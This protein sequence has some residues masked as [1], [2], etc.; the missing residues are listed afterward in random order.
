MN[1]FA[2][3]YSSLGLLI[4]L[5]LLIKPVWI[6]GIDLQVQNI[7][8]TR[9]YGNYFS[10]FNLAI[11]FSFLTDWGF[12]VFFSRSASAMPAVYINRAGSYGMLKF[13]FAILYALIVF[14]VAWVSG[15]TEWLIV[16]L[17]VL[18]QVLT[19]FYLFL[20]S[21]I[22]ATQ[23]F[24]TDAWLSVLDK[25]LMILVCGTFI[26][27]PFV[28]G[29]ISLNSFL[30]IQV[31]SLA[32]AVLAAVMILFYLKLSFTPIKWTNLNR[33]LLSAALPFAIL[34]FLMSVHNRADGF[35]LERLHANGNYEAGIYASA[36]R[37]LDAF[38]MPGNL[39][40]AFLLPFIAKKM[41]K[42]TSFSALVLNVRHFL[43]MLTVGVISIG[44][45]LA[46][47]LQ[48]L[49]YNHD[50]TYG[51]NVLQLTLFSM[52]G[53]TLIQVY[54][55]ILTAS[56]K[57]RHFVMAISITVILNLGLNL[58]MIPQMGA[59]GSALAA[60]ISQNLCGLFLAF[61]VSRKYHLPIDKRS[62][63][64][65]FFSVLTYVAVLQTGLYWQ[66]NEWL[67]ILICV[68]AGTLIVLFSKKPDW[69]NSLISIKYP[70]N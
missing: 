65:Y 14:F 41:A 64:V 16:L 42:Q 57:L 21:I 69:R 35:L 63:M 22:T 26:Y 19:S 31:L 11:I 45:M 10:I 67:L 39:M 59:K 48:N 2:R 32:V 36:Y 7:I 28:A 40:I 55:T 43:L 24:K 5:N 20:R 46:P 13:I 8:G 44:F 58:I 51:A 50:A 52:S 62:I 38:L 30:M 34:V 17:V 15:I 9:E 61:V 60:I 56:G 12:T 23:K 27:L 70:V 68:I 3:F 54:G 49:L 25:I 6:F 18:I 66:I 1:S 29:T 4:L 33:G 53:Y 47:W 37:L